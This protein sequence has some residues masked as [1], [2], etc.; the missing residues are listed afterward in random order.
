MSDPRKALERLRYYGGPEMRDEVEVVEAALEQAER[1]RDELRDR[2]DMAESE[3]ETAIENL[4][5]SRK[6]W[7]R[8][9]GSSEDELAKVPALVEALRQIED[10]AP[11]WMQ[12]DAVA[13]SERRMREIAREA[14]AAWERD[15]NTR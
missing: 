14:L 12:P 15:D 11:D 13:D 8:I 10:T 7:A 6:S 1:E 5:R 2:V 9:A 3:R 4:H